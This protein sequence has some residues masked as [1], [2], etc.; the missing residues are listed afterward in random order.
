MDEKS[1]SQSAYSIVKEKL[2]TLLTELEEVETN[3]QLIEETLQEL[4][5]DEIEA[6]EKIQTL[7]NKS[8][9]QHG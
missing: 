9:K 7:K 8:K 4:R 1:I 6:R 5:K 2:E 3:Q